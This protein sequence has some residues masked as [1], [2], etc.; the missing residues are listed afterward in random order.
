MKRLIAA[1][2]IVMSA[3]LTVLCAQGADALSGSGFI[4]ER[5]GQ[6]VSDSRAIAGK[7]SILGSYA[8]KG[9][10]SSFLQTEPAD[11]AFQRGSAYEVRFT[12]RIISEPDKGFDFLFYSKKGGDAGLW[13]PTA[14]IAGK[15]GK[16]GAIK[17]S[18]A[19]GPYDDYI[20]L[21]TIAGTGAIVVDDV[22]IFDAKGRL[23]AFLD[24][25]PRVISRAQ[26]FLPQGSIGHGYWAAP[27]VS[28]GKPPYSWTAAGTLP[29]GM[30]LSAKG[31]LSGTPAEEGSFPIA[32]Y[33]KDSLGR[34]SL[35]SYKLQ[36]GPP[37]AAPADPPRITVSGDRS[38]GAF[39]LTV[40]PNAY[41]K[42]FRNP[43]KGMR[44]Y[45]ESARTHP[46]ASLGKRYVEWKRIEDQAG[47]TVE[48][49]REEMDK[50][51]GDLPSYN[52]KVILRVYL[53][54]PPDK[55]YWPSDLTPGDYSSPAFRARM[56]ALIR[57]I[58]EAWNADPRIAYVELGIIGDWGEN[59]TPDF[60]NVSENNHLPPDMMKE[61]GDAYWDAFPDKLLMRRYP[62]DFAGYPFGV[63]WDVFGAFDRGFWGNDTTGMTAE[64]NKPGM[65][66]LWKTAVMGGEIDPT[67]LDLPG[68][69][70]ESL[71][72]V[73]RLYG[74]RIA[75]TARKL[76]WNHLAVLETIDPAD[77]DLWNKASDIQNALGYR[78]MIDEA[79]YPGR[80]EAGKSL[81]LSMSIRNTGSSPFYYKWPLEI[82]LLD[83]VNHRPVLKKTLDD[84]D[85]RIW[86]PDA[87]VEIK[88][89][90]AIPATLRKGRYIL[91][92]T[93]LDP[94]G[95][96]PAAR[97]AVESYFNG[98]RTPLG[99]VGVSA[100]PGSFEI[101]GFDD[102]Q[103]DRSLYYMPGG[104]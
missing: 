42:A 101:G 57:K 22:R 96:V 90:V 5:A 40:R 93:I 39:M 4:L 91:S 76:H 50:L 1:A 33:V 41:A 20:A 100:D 43:L 30:S 54:W 88:A 75:G 28:G 17:H 74:D 69:S 67:F 25:E 104:N 32:A 16:T 15:A 2:A 103:A 12:Y 11:I 65:A 36:I 61:L 92:I 56:K 55:Y 45:I 72:S 27:A 97:F 86:L 81:E 3:S 66:D 9:S 64:M 82:A 62:R 80:V 18:N 10:Y 44:P 29:R 19:L 8:G 14:H 48:K 6:I 78:F 58:G 68:W 95:M 24:A 23:V 47:D 31:E 21:W 63:H 52:I 94:A 73:V 34:S 71:E 87:A 60:G 26:A 77:T 51:I 59:H 37:A 85:I 46:F 89:N 99:P 7:C 35:V 98:G 13:L 102:L 83:P 38:S 84:V 53:K 79:S 70:R 49:I